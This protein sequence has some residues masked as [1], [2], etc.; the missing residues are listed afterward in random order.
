MDN[1]AIWF[2]GIFKPQEANNITIWVIDANH[3]EGFLNICHES[4][5]IWL[6][7]D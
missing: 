5:G 4:N 6:K 7:S 3:K 2:A 1:A